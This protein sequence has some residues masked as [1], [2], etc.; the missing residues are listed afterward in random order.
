MR[1]CLDGE[2]LGKTGATVAPTIRKTPSFQL[3]HSDYLVPPRWSR[4]QQVSNTA[5]SRADAVMDS[6]MTERE[7]RSH[8]GSECLG[9][10]R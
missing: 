10:H 8:P 5:C 4:V 9:M 7:A 6:G 1:L 2:A 3:V